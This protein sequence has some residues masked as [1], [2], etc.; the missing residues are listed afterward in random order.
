MT[1]EHHEMMADIM[2]QVFS[3][4]V[5]GIAQSRSLP[6]ERVRALLVLRTFFLVCV[7]S[8]YVFVSLWRVFLQAWL[9]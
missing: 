8:L 3:Q 7:K 9:N 4:M 5:T 2:N 6:E 1:A